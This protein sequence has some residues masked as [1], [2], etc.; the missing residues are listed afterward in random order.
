MLEYY[1]R[2][3]VYADACAS[4][5]QPL[6][7][8]Q[9]LGAKAVTT[10]DKGSTIVT[11]ANDRQRPFIEWIETLAWNDDLINRHQSFIKNNPHRIICEINRDSSSTPVRELLYL[12]IYIIFRRM[13]IMIWWK[14]HRYLCRSIRR[15]RFV[16]SL[17]Q[18]NHRFHRRRLCN[19]C[20]LLLLWLRSIWLLSNLQKY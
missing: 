7:M 14:I 6:P 1:P 20:Y 2:R 12:K 11:D 15:I 19:I 5:N 8:M 18:V 10:D 9:A 4:Y 16:R 3:R 13:I 17:H